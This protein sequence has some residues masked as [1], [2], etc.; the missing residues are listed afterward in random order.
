MTDGV[1]VRPLLEALQKRGAGQPHDPGIGTLETLRT[2]TEW[3]GEV[4]PQQMVNLKRAL[5][6][7]TYSRFVIIGIDSANHCIQ[8]GFEKS[9]ISPE[10][11]VIEVR[12]K[13]AV[14]LILG[15]GWSISRSDTM[16]VTDE[17]RPDTSKSPR[18]PKPK[19]VRGSKKTRKR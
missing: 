2:C 19:R 6:L 8:Y 14:S 17:P 1:D 9:T 16:D 5:M 11:S 4:F 3:T 10:A 12:F 18:R 7:I 13:D 15:K